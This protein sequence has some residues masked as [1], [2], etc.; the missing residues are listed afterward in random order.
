MVTSRLRVRN[1]SGV[2]DAFVRPTWTILACVSDTR[3]FDGFV[4]F[5]WSAAC[6]YG[7]RAAF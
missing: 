4:D 6:T 5:V 7:C 1:Y 3:V 2:I